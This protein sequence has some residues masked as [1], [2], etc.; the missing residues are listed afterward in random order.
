LTLRLHP[1]RKTYSA[2]IKHRV[3]GRVHL[4]LRTKT[5]AV[6]INRYAALNQLLDTGEPVRDLVNALRAEKLTIESVTECARAKRPFDMLRAST[7]PALGAAVDEYVEA[8][9]GKEDGA[10]RTAQ[11][12]NTALTHARAFFG[13][14]RSLESITH[15]DV[16]AFKESLRAAGLEP[17]TIALYL[18]KFGALYTY[19]QRRETR[20]AQQQKRAPAVLFSPLDRDEHIPVPIKTRARFLTESEAEHVLAAT[21]RVMQAAVAIGLFAGLRIGEVHMLRPTVDVDMERGVIYVQAREGWQPKYGR[22]REVPISS[23]LEPFLAAHM[24]Q[25]APDAAYLYRG[26]N[27][28][29]P[30]ALTVLQVTFRQIVKDAG[31]IQD[32][33]HADTVTFHTLRHTFASWLVMAGADLFT[34]ARLMGHTTTKQ[35]EATY[36]HLTPGHRLFT[37]EMLTRRWAEH[38]AQ[39]D[40]ATYRDTTDA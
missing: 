4:H 19:L 18:V 15:D 20:R 10:A 6:A 38:A 29:D 35:V 8:Q 12:S 40:S 39:Q 3:F 11:S 7:W 9:R 24:A 36:A 2:D 32:R 16:T 5:K 37:V 14:E 13:D 28:R 21:P 31:L 25:L 23:V 30:M 1:E 26:Q 33:K 27:P 34:V 17:N 22:N